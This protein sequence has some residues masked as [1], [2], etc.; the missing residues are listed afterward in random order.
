MY[1]KVYKYIENDKAKQQVPEV[2]EDTPKIEGTWNIHNW[3]WYYERQPQKNLQNHSPNT[4]KWM[5]MLNTGC[6]LPQYQ[7]A[8]AVQL[9]WP[10]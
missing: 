10:I 8:V 6:P 9:T 5:I 3:M 2:D 1:M 7:V 4:L